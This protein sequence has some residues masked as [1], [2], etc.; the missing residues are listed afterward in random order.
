MSE[1][2]LRAGYNA[3]VCK[4]CNTAFRFG[5]ED[6]CEP[7]NDNS[8]TSHFPYVI[9]PCCKHKIYFGWNKDC[10]FKFQKK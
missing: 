3:C 7:K 9:C 1:K 2:I 4:L 6:I 8:I 10:F 5:N